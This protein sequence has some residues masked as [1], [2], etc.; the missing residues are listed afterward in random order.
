MAAL[1]NHDGLHISSCLFPV[2]FGQSLMHVPRH[3]D[4]FAR[5]VRTA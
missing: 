5:I 1:K 4:G 3:E 2:F